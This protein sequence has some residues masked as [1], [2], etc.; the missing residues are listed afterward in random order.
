MCWTFDTP[1]EGQFKA[2]TVADMIEWVLRDL[3]TMLQL[4]VKVRLLFTF[5]FKVKDV[6]KERG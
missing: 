3:E 6:V 5:S 4:K 1:L 2:N